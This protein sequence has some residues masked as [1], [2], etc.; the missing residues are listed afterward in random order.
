[1][2]FRDRL[3]LG[4]VVLALAATGAQ[5]G[6]GFV[7][8]RATLERDRASDLSAYAVLVRSVL[9]TSGEAPTVIA[10]RLP[11]LAETEGRFRVTQGGTV[12]LEGG[13]RF[14]AEGQGWRSSSQ[15]LPGRSVLEVA[16]DHA[17]V[18]EATAAYLR[19]SLVALLAT[20]LFAV[21]LAVLMRG[22]LLRP[23]ER[24]RRASEALAQERFPEP[25][26]VRG[27]DELARLARTFNGMATQLKRSLERERAFTRYASHELR[28]PLASLKATAEAVRAGAMDADALV[29]VAE[30]GV[31]RMERTLA[32][33]L[34]LARAPGAHE[35]VA[36]PALLDE[37]LAGLPAEARARVHLSVHGGEVRVPRA[38]FEGALRNLLDNALRHGAGAV[39]LSLEAGS[40]EV[41]L[42][43][44]DEGT[45]VPEAALARLGEPFHRGPS[46]AAGSGLG[47]A[48]IRQLA[49]ELGGRLELE[50]RTSGGFEAR[51][52]LPEGGRP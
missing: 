35:P 51:L 23:L 34:A 49:D 50:N 42:A 25:L 41:R 39:W 3:L 48:Y 32:G 15:A 10:A 30:R 46:R 19:T 14:P 8:F 7:R 45:G 37:V 21:A 9:D 26:E 18:S 12:L 2:A 40:G 17:E 28:T 33:L 24:L 43:V 47:L 31:E 38:A 44:R 1:M 22:V 27:S 20:L 11:V 5:A 6:L 13:G 16:L 36:A 52:T 29:P 4:L